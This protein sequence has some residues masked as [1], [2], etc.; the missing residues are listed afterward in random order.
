MERAKT[1]IPV[2]AILYLIIISIVWYRD[3]NSYEK[4]IVRNN[5]HNLTSIEASEN[6]AEY[7]PNKNYYSETQN[8][9][10]YTKKMIPFFFHKKLIDSKTKYFSKS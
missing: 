10:T 2:F 4:T 5:T 6:I 1:L 9:Y 3:I 8:T 7:N